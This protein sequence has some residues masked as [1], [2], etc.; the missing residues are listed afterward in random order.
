MA[1][2]TSSA[3]MRKRGMW[4]LAA[5]PLRMRTMLLGSLLLLAIVMTLVYFAI[6]LFTLNRQIRQDLES[7][8]Q[9]SVITFA[10]VQAQ[11]RKSLVVNARLIADLPSLKAL[12]SAQDAS[13][14]ADG[15][16]EFWRVSDS[17]FLALSDQSGRLVAYYNDASPLNRA[18]VREAVARSISHPGSFEMLS[19]QRRLF[20]ILS[21]PISFGDE[22]NG[23]PLGS[24]TVG[25]TQDL[26]LAREVREAAAAEIAF[27]YARQVFVSTLAPATSEALLQRVRTGGTLPEGDVRLGGEL[28]RLKAVPLS[29]SGA[30]DGAYLLVLKSHQR[31]ERTLRE[32]TIG[33][34]IM[35]LLGLYVGVVLA[36]AMARVVTTPL[37]SLLEG[38]RA[39]GAGE[40]QYHWQETGIAETRELG[41]AFRR[42]GVQIEQAQR[43]LL[44]SDRMATIGRMASSISHD[45]RH[46][47]TSIYANAEFLST[48]TSSGI[49]RDEM[50]EEVR[51]AV[52]GMTDLL[53]SMMLFGRGEARLPTR[54]VEL[55][56]VLR[57][58]VTR[59]LKHP[60]TRGVKLLMDA[61]QIVSVRVVPQEIDRAVYNL[62]LNACQAARKSV[63][64][65]RV[66]LSMAAD[67]TTVRVFIEDNGAGVPLSIHDRLFQPFVSAGKENG[68]GLG[69]ALSRHI[70]ELHGGDLKMQESASG[71]TVFSLMLPLSTGRNQ[72]ATHSDAGG[73]TM[74]RS[75]LNRGDFACRLCLL[76]FVLVS[77][78]SGQASVAAKSAAQDATQQRLHQLEQSLAAAQD[79]IDLLRQNLRDLTSQWNAS[80]QSNAESGVP[81]DAAQTLAHLEE[82]AEV[83][84][85]QVKQHEQTKVESD[86]KFPVHLTGMVL[87]NAFAN[88]GAVDAIDLPTSALR[89]QP[90]ESHGNV[91]G[92]MRQTWLGLEGRGPILGGLRTSARIDFDFFGGNTYGTTTDPSR[93]REATY[94]RGESRKHQKPFRSAFRSAAYFAAFTRIDCL[95]RSTRTGVERQSMDMG[96][97]AALEAQFPRWQRQDL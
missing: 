4:R 89:R 41:V 92:S 48:G 11:R 34:A 65:P 13:T 25:Y 19:A 78:G 23:V 59:V 2:V 10:N 57:R 49:D 81:L 75:L 47:L 70:L 71:R 20:E 68:T 8:T 18:E 5:R 36:A 58:S 40:F 74:T 45:L 17:S 54:E 64:P 3:L 26:A 82:N 6:V 46:Y 90:G 66:W 37:E 97:G 1:Q 69:L 39:F 56:E 38:A 43:E 86:S 32:L 22:N 52:V 85:A 76:C 27:L 31:A 60:D 94:R 53:D 93:H 84:A 79:Q 73:G 9:R 14:I 51:A 44:A 7:D 55:T 63:E 30:S 96:T 88:A 72:S 21:A 67:L 61:K 77:R 16:R 42:M 87:F 83:L 29:Y 33:I 50:L 62:L 80:A 95:Y 28:F 91:G 24:V 15:G 35:G 12:M